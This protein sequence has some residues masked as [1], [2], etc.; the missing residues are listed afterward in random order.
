MLGALRCHTSWI[1]LCVA[2]LP[3]VASAQD[4]P[5]SALEDQ[6][7]HSA[8]DGDIVVTARKQAENLQRIPVAVT[9]QSG[10]ELQRKNIRTLENLGS[11]VPSLQI[12][13]ASQT[14]TGIAV[15]LRGQEPGGADLTLSQPVGIYIDNVNISR[16]I[17][18]NGSFFDVERVEV[19]KGPQ[20]TLY[21]KNT[22]GGAINIITRNAD[23]DGVHG[24][25]AGE[26]GN[27]SNW[28]L[29]AAINVPLIPDVLAI[30]LAGEHW[31]REGVGRN[32]LAKRIGYDRD[33]SIVR[34][35]LRFDPAPG[36][37][38]TTKV[39]YVRM[40]RTGNSLA[41]YGLAP[42]TP[43]QMQAGL[44]AG[45]SGFPTPAF[46]GCASA[47]VAPYV[48]TTGHYDSASTGDAYVRDRVWHVSHDMALDVTDNLSLRSI[49]GF[50]H[51]R[52]FYAQDVDGTPFQIIEINNPLC[53]GLPNNP[54]KAGPYQVNRSFTQ[55]L[56]LS[57]KAFGGRLSYLLGV[58]GSWDKGHQQ[59]YTEIFPLLLGS[60][61][62][63]A[64]L[65]SVKSS[66][67][68]VYG[69]ADFKITDRLTLTGGLRYTKERQSDIA[70]QWTYAFLSGRYNCLVPAPGQ[71]SGVQ[72][73]DP[74]NCP[75]LTNAISSHGVSYLAS[76]NWQATPDVL[77]YAKT[78]RG[79]R[80]GALQSIAPGARPVLPE[81][82][83]DIEIGLKSELFDR[84]VRLNVAAYRTSYNNKQEK[85]T[86]SD[87]TLCGPGVVNG[88][89]LLQNAANARIWGVEAEM[90]A[91][92]TDGLTLYGTATW[93]KGTYLSYRN[94][95]G[96]TGPLFPGAPCNPL[97]APSP[98]P[99]PEQCIAHD[100][101]FA[102]P[103]WQGSVG[104]RYETAAGPGRV[105]AQLDFAFRSRQHANFLNVDPSF[106][107]DV[108]A[109]QIANLRATQLLNARL[110]YNFHDDG[111]MIA[112]F[113]TNLLDKQYRRVTPQG[114]PLNIYFQ[115]YSEPRMWGV[116][117]RKTFGG[118]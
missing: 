97:G 22:T 41:L 38:S 50:N 95:L 72:V 62:V 24:F 23:H 36:F 101:P 73:A 71:S 63:A 33:D 82:A 69:Q 29:G 27:H 15:T 74:A 52:E 85:I 32:G 21:G 43:V 99:L 4:E 109:A 11:I 88:C 65:G 64:Q 39:E 116:Q 25:L 49:T 13:P 55:E 8:S 105:A 16:P 86:T 78:A 87:N 7:I 35:S 5:Q 30:R 20:G 51:V 61:G 104:G 45:C 83:T 26:V 58:F 84:R 106:P 66:S 3:S 9:A 28:R 2:A 75:V 34:A 56:D 91:R 102:L 118:G 110:E 111:L 37:T 108:Y 12:T 90:N 100:V 117:L 67:K 68:A 94:P 44:Q 107:Q 17:G 1:V 81:R 80:A 70:P 76:V 77:V 46:F 92:V 42:G 113:A 60:E 47:A 14:V 31:D 54:I 57:G 6:S 10:V 19:L 114:P 115:S 40:N 89:N 18:L 112:L 96:Q 79:F 59:Q 98:S 93:Q 53:C 48:G 103:T